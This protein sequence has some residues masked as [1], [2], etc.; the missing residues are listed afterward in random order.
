MTDITAMHKHLPW[1]QSHCQNTEDAF[2]G[3]TFPE[4]LSCTQ[5]M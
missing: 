2:F 1:Y 3:I 5:A 4:N